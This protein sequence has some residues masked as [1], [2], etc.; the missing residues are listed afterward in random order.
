M[1]GK[2]EEVTKPCFNRLC[3]NPGVKRCTLCAYAVYCSRECQVNHWKEHKACCKKLALPENAA[4]RDQA[5]KHVRTAIDLQQ[6]GQLDKALRKYREVLAI[7]KDLVGED[8]ENTASI[9]EHI[10]QILNVKELYEESLVEHRK[11]LGIRRLILGE[12]NRYTATSYDCIGNVLFHQGRCD[13]TLIGFGKALSVRFKIFGE[14]YIDTAT[15]YGNVGCVLFEK[16]QHQEA[17][18]K[19]C[20]AEA[21]FKRDLGK[22]HLKTNMITKAI[23]DIAKAYK[24][25]KNI[26][27]LETSAKLL[28]A[29]FSAA[30]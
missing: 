4:R 20:K 17:L 11:A 10:G 12:N 21:I 23:D 24:R 18:E 29:K 22:N 5:A 26:E 13:D 9:Y 1:N 25:D 8:D 30:A 7:F 19:L 6:A 14:N 15:S 2:V 27:N 3:C 16:H 28:R